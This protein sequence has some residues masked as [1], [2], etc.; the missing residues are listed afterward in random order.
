[1]AETDAR[2]E[3]DSRASF[4][5]HRER[6]D[7]FAAQIDAFVDEAKV[8]FE[9]DGLRTRAVDPA[10]VAMVET[11]LD[12]AAFDRY[13][14]D[15][16]VIGANVARLRDVLGAVEADVRAEVS[17]HA[18]AQKYDLG[19]GDA[20]MTLA[21]IDPDAVRR[22]PDLPDLDNPAQV[23]MDQARLE[24]IV[25]YAD[26]VDDHVIFGYD[27]DE[28]EFTATAMGDTDDL[29]YWVHA[30]ELNDATATGDAHSP[31]SLDYLKDA[32]ERI[33]DG[34]EVIL[35]LGEQFPMKWEYDFGPG[36]HGHVEY[37]LAPRIQ[38]GV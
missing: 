34:T 6:L 13:D 27:H 1:M 29:D 26:A 12:A 14:G 19:L 22:E 16:T 15:G 3:P 24:A 18:D 20:E 23:S 7:E 38:D 37:V 25:E 9:A 31:F 33:P 2:G 21:Y 11:T 32:V 10:N 5:I 8:C 4:A 35:H 28:R 17:V 30:S 36:G